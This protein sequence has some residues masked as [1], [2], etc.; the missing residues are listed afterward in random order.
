MNTEAISTALANHKLAELAADRADAALERV[1]AGGQAYVTVDGTAL[2]VPIS[3]SQ[4]L[5]LLEGIAT[6][7]R[8]DANVLARRLNAAAR[9]I[10][11][12]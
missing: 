11:E 5:T 10:D 4:A 9:R 2:P 1:R 12:E 7:R 3:E 6:Q 8:T